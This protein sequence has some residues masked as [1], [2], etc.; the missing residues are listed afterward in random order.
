[1]NNQISVVLIIPSYNETL[2]LPGLLCELK[3]GLTEHDAVIIMD[4]SPPIIFEEIKQKCLRATQGSKFVLMFDNSGSK[5][6]RGAAVRRGMEVALT[7]FPIVEKILECDADGSHRSVDI[8]K[9]KNSESTSDLLVGSRYLSTS[10]IVGWPLGRRIFS[11]FLNQSIPKL[12][13][14]NLHDITNGLRRYSKNAVTKVL[15]EKQKNKGFIYLSEQAILI[16]RAGMVLSEE[17]IIF[18]DRTLGKST[19][20]WREI[21]GSLYGIFR[22]VLSNRKP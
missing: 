17:P 4:D 15:S 20:T 18:I 10:K 5:S 13:R 12:T 16:S 8:L 3:E 6:G 7:Q 9:L 22:L 1:M 19:V 2:A 11:W 14:V 21:S